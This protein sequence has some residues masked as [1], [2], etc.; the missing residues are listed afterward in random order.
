MNLSGLPSP[1]AYAFHGEILQASPPW[2]SSSRASNPAILLE[3]L[4]LKRPSDPPCGYTPDGLS[5]LCLSPQFFEPIVA[6][7]LICKNFTTLK[8]LPR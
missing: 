8:H 6:I 2:R 7:A 5:C 1:P 4:G 3:L